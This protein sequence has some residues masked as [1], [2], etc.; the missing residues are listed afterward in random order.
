M[1][2]LEIAKGSTLSLTTNV[3]KNGS[4]MAL[5]TGVRVLFVAKVNQTD[6]DSAA[7]ALLDNIGLGGVSVTDSV[8]G[9]VQTT[10]PASSTYSLPAS[11]QS[12][13]YE[14]WVKDLLSNEFRV[15]KGTIKLTARILVQQ[16]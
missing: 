10:M 4:P 12:L 1:A 8:N 16:P 6:A 3:T 5:P 2:L 15:D 14:I 7:V 11:V 9:I 13:Y